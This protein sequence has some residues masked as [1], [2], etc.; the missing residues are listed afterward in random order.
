MEYVIGGLEK[1]PFIV[2]D[3]GMLVP[4]NDVPPP[5]TVPWVPPPTTPP[6]APPVAPGVWTPLPAF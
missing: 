6:V 2:P 5:G 3:V 1:F 4:P